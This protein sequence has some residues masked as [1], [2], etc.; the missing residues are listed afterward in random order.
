MIDDGQ[1]EFV[2]GGYVSPDEATTNYADVLRNFEG[3]H[4]FLRTEFGV[5]PRVAWQLD[6]FGHSAVMASLA[7]DMGMEAMFFARINK[8]KFDELGASEDLEFIW[9]PAFA[10][11]E[12]FAHALHDHYNPPEFLDRNVYMTGTSYDKADASEV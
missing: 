11:N 9:K 7:A 5:T 2:H 12:I 4:D 3:A 8:D 10:S 1:L 6:P